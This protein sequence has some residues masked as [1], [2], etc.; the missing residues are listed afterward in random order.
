ML[1]CFG[2]PLH[3]VLSKFHEY[4]SKHTKT[5][6]AK[7]VALLTGLFLLA[8]AMPAAAA[9]SGITIFYN[10]MEKQFQPAPQLVNDRV[11]V[12][13]R[14]IFEALG[15]EISWD[16]GSSTAIAFKDGKYVA[17]QVGSKVGVMADATL[18]GGKY[19][20]RNSRNAKLDAAPIT[21][22]SRTMVPLRF[23]SEAL[24]ADVQWF[25]N[26]SQIFIK[27]G[28]AATPPSNTNQEMRGV[29]LSYN[30]LAGFDR[31]KIDSM[32]DKAAAMKLNTVFVHAR[33]FSDAFYK[34]EIFP[35]S[36]KLTGVQGQAP[37][38]DPL[39][40]IITAG[41]NRG[42]RVEAW[43]NPYRISTSTDLTNSLAPGNPA[44]KWLADPSKVI[45]YEANGEE[46]LIYNPASQDVRNLITAGALEIVNNYDVD[47]I[48]FDDYFY[49]TGTGE[50]YD[51]DF[52]EN[53]VNKLVQQVYAAVKAANPA[54][55]FGISP[56][57]NIANCNA[58]G[59]DVQT[60]LS[61]NGYV[62]YVCPQIYWT[63]EYI[64]PQYQFNNVLNDWLAMKQ[65]PNV[66]LYVGLALYR[67]ATSSSSDPGW[68][69][70]NDNLVTQ[71]RHIRSTGQCSGFV[72]FDISNLLDPE[73]QSELANLK[74]AL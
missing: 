7:A 69:D 49:V 8:M 30:D 10:G 35:W 36:H 71:L 56:A 14:A 28:G 23:V 34:S 12:P 13:M 29:W 33:A 41:H 11:L 57:G 24:G 25:G 9:D 67:V 5:V 72:L 27:P 15:A 4:S 3:L 61:Q 2:N 63:N 52:K 68:L 70:R 37:A 19:Q 45:H 54:L 51:T 32:L 62:D 17:V 48:H 20:L 42:L 64:K 58:A 31:S 74:G 44:V 39:Q 40:Y 26:T 43:I 47:G 6:R 16:A 55:S 1:Y 66:K 60:W 59:A 22:N 50:D 18:V 21:V 38:V 65:N 53:Q 46:C 73:A